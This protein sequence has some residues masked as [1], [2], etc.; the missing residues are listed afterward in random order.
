MMRSVTFACVALLAAGCGRS[1]GDAAT[2]SSASASAAPAAPLTLWERAAKLHRESIVVDTHDDVTSTILEDGFDL[3][4]PDG[5]TATDL[6]KMR[7]GGIG[8]EFFSI[9]VD[10]RFYQ[11]PSARDG[12]LHSARKWC[13]RCSASGCSWTSRT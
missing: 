1:S 3:G 11:H 2:S 4:K 13:A 8:A 9:Y 6:A 12:S 10:P 5:K 7:A